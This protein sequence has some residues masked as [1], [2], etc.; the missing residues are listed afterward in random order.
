MRYIFIFMKNSS[1]LFLLLIFAFNACQHPKNTK[2]SLNLTTQKTKALAFTDTTILDTFKVKLIGKNIKVMEIL[3]TITNAK[4]EEIYNV[5]INAN[6]LINS[7][8]STLKLSN[9]ADKINFLNEEIN[10][11]FDEENYLVPAVMP[12]EKQNV[13]VMDNTFYQELKQTQRNGFAYKLGKDL[14]IYVAWCAKEN[15]V[16]IYYKCC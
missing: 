14:K 5:K 3:F 10:I 1:I 2:A 12:N 15:K 16:K 7:Y 6:T 4:K 8:L 11:F 9:E 13:N